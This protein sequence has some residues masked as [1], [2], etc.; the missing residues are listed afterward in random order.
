MI[1]FPING[2]AMSYDY[3]SPINRKKIK[4]SKRFLADKVR[5]SRRPMREIHKFLVK[6]KNLP[7]EV[8]SQERVEDRE[9][10]KQKIEEFQLRQLTGTS[11]V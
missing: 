8:S 10:W 3:L 5:K 9:V 1:K 2:A 7:V 6:W 11:T 4:K